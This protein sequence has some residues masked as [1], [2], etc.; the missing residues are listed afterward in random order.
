M[1][2]HGGYLKKEVDVTTKKVD[3]KVDSR[4]HQP[5][6]QTASVNI[7]ALIEEKIIQRR[8]TNPPLSATIP[9]SSLLPPPSVPPHPL[10]SS[11][12]SSV[13]RSFVNPSPSSFPSTLEATA[14]SDLDPPNHEELMAFAGSCIN[15][16]LMRHLP[17]NNRLQVPLDEVSSSSLHNDSSLQDS[18]LLFQQQQVESSASYQRSSE[19]DDAQSDMQRQIEIIKQGLMSHQPPLLEKFRRHSDSDHFL[20]P[21]S[22][23]LGSLSPSSVTDFLRRKVSGKRT[24]RTGS[25]PGEFSVGNL[26]EMFSG[27]LVEMDE[28][29]PAGDVGDEV[30][31]D[32]L[33]A[34]QTHDTLPTEDMIE[35]EIVSGDEGVAASPPLPNFSSSQSVVMQSTPTSCIVVNAHSEP[36][37]EDARFNDASLT[38]VTIPKVKV[39][40]DDDVFLSPSSIPTS[41]IRTKKK[42]RPEPLYIPPH[43]ST[44]GFQSRLR[45]PRLWDSMPGGRISSPPPYTPPPMLSPVRSAPGLFWHVINNSGSLTPKSA[46]LTPGK[47][48]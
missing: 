15:E 7:R 17:P 48:G 24:Q 44:C 45:S 4:P 33:Q 38:S 3:K 18:E 25:D 23:H 1:R 36:L 12:V 13:Q 16:P 30:G 28:C 34:M 2:L 41:P 20:A 39:E 9:T 10:P 42:H 29:S 35:F 40:E 47:L 26:E 14:N 8:I 43:A 46:P 19:D 32:E 22:Y 31:D 5:P 27:T 6:L 11:L 37:S 21:R